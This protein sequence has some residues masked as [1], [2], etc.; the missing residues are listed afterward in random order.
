VAVGGPFESR[1]P[2]NCSCC[3]GPFESKVPAQ[4]SFCRGPFESRVLTNDL[5]CG[6]LYEWI[7]SFSSK[8]RKIYARNTSRGAPK[9]GGRGKCLARLP[10]N[11]PLIMRLQEIS[12]P[13]EFLFKEALQHQTRENIR[14]IPQKF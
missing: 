10:L 12:F 1:L 2:S 6:T 5:L 9:K 11:T 8:I 13:K 14:E 7:I 3:W 4:Y